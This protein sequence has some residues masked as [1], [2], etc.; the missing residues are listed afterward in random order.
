M[1][2]QA[3]ETPDLNAGDTSANR[4]NISKADE[5]NESGVPD[6]AQDAIS[7]L[8]ADH[9]KIKQLFDSYE[10][11]TRRSERARLVQEVCDALAIHTAL[12]EEIFYPACREL[13]DDEPL[14]EAQV[15]HDSAKVLINEL[16]SGS[17]ED[18]FYDAKFEVLADQVRHHIQ[19]EEGKSDS[20]FAKARSAGADLAALGEKLK[21]RKAELSERA[22][23]KELHAKPLSFKSFAK[24][25]EEANMGSYQRGRDYDERGSSRYR[26]EQPRDEQGRFASDEDRRGRE[27]G[28]RERD[29]SDYRS[30]SSSHGRSYQDDEYT[31]RGQ[32]MPE[33]DEYG[34]FM[35]DDDRRS[36]GYSRG[37]DYEEERRASHG[38]GH[39][40]WFGDPEGHSEAARK[41]WDEREGERR[42]YDED[43]RG[44]SSQGGG[45][46]YKSRSRE[47][48]GERRHSGHG[49][50]FGDPEGHSEAARRGWDER[51]G[52]RRSY[53]EDTRGYS[54]QGGGR[55]Y[56]SRSREDEGERRH[57]GHGGW[58]GD[59]EGHSQASRRGWHHRG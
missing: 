14:D 4:E 35:S 13:I 10:T 15:E 11:L 56:E 26:D 59:P 32:R 44:Y 41:G 21:E 18:P 43:T 2:K 33:R 8:E 27:Y 9:A 23:R 50:W 55:R 7:L 49:G 19:E 12:E 24:L 53:D 36:Q 3:K 20:I 6:S 48:E 25:V 5:K 1:V 38:G 17:P 31:S 57:S 54:S 30:S 22:A 39:G 52:E 51:E 16:L 37:R 29:D 46:R 34:R 45:R 47:D 28:R 42:S 40:G 58:F